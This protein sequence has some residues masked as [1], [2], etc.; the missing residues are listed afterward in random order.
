MRG[1]EFFTSDLFDQSGELDGGP[2][3][4][5]RAHAR[6]EAMIG[7]YRSPV[8]DNIREGLRRLFHDEVT[9]G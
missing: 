7:G 4:I 9:R 1:G 2:S 8:P 6:V 3:L 5:E